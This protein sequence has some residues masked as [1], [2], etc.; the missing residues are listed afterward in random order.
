[1]DTTNQTGLAFTFTAVAGYSFMP[2]FTK[3]VYAYS[4]LTPFDVSGWRFLAGVPLVWLILWVRRANPDNALP[5]LKF[6][7]LGVL[8][9]IGALCIAFGLEY[10]DASLYIVLMRV[11]PAVLMTMMALFLGERFGVRGWGAL[12]MVL[13]GM[14]LIKPDVFTLS[15]SRSDLIG[16]SIAILH[17]FVISFYNIGQQQFTR[18]V[19]SKAHATA[20]TMTGTLLTLLPLW[21]L[22]GEF[23]AP[24]NLAGSV[25]IAGLVIFCTVL[26]ILAMYEA[27]ARIG[28]SRYALLASVSPV[29]SV[30]L[31]FLLLGERVVPIQILG[32]L[33]ILASV[34]VLELK[35]LPWRTTRPD[36]DATT[37]RKASQNV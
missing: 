28:A 16:V 19:A 1:M 2:I 12:G 10:V 8:L 21:T 5:R 26:P 4:D 37:T 25:N 30:T 11:Q 29:I 14:L 20:W 13:V 17:V 18:G 3:F 35:R 34:P 9:A 24:N 6:I 22:I 31:A 33:L 27:I 15:L 7:G 23:Q 32:G 36:I